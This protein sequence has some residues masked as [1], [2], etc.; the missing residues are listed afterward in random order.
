MNYHLVIVTPRGDGH[1]VVV[2]RTVLFED[3]QRLFSV[4]GNDSGSGRSSGTDG[5][6]GWSSNSRMWVQLNAVR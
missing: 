2:S 6:K 1:Y 5:E 4:E 3:A